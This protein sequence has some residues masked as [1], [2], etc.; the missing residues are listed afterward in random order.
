MTGVT[1][2]ATRSDGLGLVITALS[3]EFS[4]GP[5]SW[6]AGEWQTN[7]DDHRTIAASAYPRCS[8]P[9]RTVSVCGRS[10]GRPVRAGRKGERR[11]DPV[12]HFGRLFLPAGKQ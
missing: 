5:K 12:V 7:G 10:V 11:R 2:N 8:T 3:R 1:A 4:K 9:P 6:P